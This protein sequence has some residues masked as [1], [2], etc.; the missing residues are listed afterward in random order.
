MKII[1]RLLLSIIFCFSTPYIYAGSQ[2][3]S[4]INKN[5]DFKEEIISQVLAIQKSLIVPVN[6][7]PEAYQQT[8]FL[9]VPMAPEYILS[10]FFINF[11]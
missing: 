8:G 9:L 4:I 6:D 3:I 7:I 5:H 2:W 10:L 11:I 1:L